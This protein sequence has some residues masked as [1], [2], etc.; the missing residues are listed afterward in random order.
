MP[1]KQNQARPA[2]FRYTEPQAK[3]ILKALEQADLLKGIDRQVLL[4]SVTSAA[5]T[6]LAQQV[7]PSRSYA[8]NV[9]KQLMRV[10]KESITLLEACSALSDSAES[11]LH[12]QLA[13]SYIDPN[14]EGA[15][16]PFYGLGPTRLHALLTALAD[17][18]LQIDAAIRVNSKLAKLR[19]A[20]TYFPTTGLRKETT[21]Q[22]F[23]SDL[24]NIY[25][26]FTDQLPSLT[27]PTNASFTKGRFYPFV[28][29]AVEP[30]K[31]ATGLK[32][33]HAIRAA[34]S[35]YRNRLDVSKRAHAPKVKTPRQ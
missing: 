13:K 20:Q 11:W 14:L 1:R 30:T 7:F 23:I 22:Q 4:D 3:N 34:T 15:L 29:A 32:L 33:D 35:A 18:A 19:G 9:A 27:R 31:L 5:R 10:A 25:H 28:V 8:G 24:C 12:A 17:A 26:Q 16:R 2:L 21:L 6:A